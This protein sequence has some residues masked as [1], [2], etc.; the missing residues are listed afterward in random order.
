M[1]ILAY[2]R[3]ISAL[4]GIL[5]L[6]SGAWA[7]PAGWWNEGYACR[8]TVQVLGGGNADDAAIV[9]FSTGGNMRA[10]AE[11]LRVVDGNGAE[12]PYYVVSAGFDDACTVAF[13]ADSGQTQYYLYYGNRFVDRP[14]YTWQPKRGLILEVRTRGAGGFNNWQEMQQLVANSPEVQGRAWH[15]CVFD[16]HNPFG[17][18][19]NYIG[20]YRGYL[21]FPSSG[22]Y[23][24]A[25]TSDDASFLLID[26]K[27]TVQWPGVHGAVADARH[28][29]TV[30][31]DAGLHLFEYYHVETDAGQTAEA[32]WRLPGQTEFQV[33]PPQSFAPF[34]QARVVAY[35]QIEDPKPA[36]FSWWP[37]NSL[38]VNDT[39]IS[40]V[41]F[42][43]DFPASIGTVNQEWD[44]GD[45]LT[46]ARRAPLHVYAVPGK[47][48]VSLTLGDK[49]VTNTIRVCANERVSDTPEAEI[50][51]SFTKVINT[52][53]LS[54]IREDALPVLAD[55]GAV[56]ELPGIEQKALDTLR[57][58]AAGFRDAALGR[59]LI[60]HAETLRKLGRYEETL[61]LLKEL[62]MRHQ[63]NDVALTALG[64]VA[65]LSMVFGLDDKALE[66]YE[67]FERK[68]QGDA[69]RHPNALAGIGDVYRH[70]GEGA[71]ALDY[72]TKAQ[73]ERNIAPAA[74]ATMRGAFAQSMMAQIRDARA[75]VAIEEAAKWEQAL[76]IDRFGGY[77]S[78]LKACAYL[79]LGD[80]G[81]ARAE[82]ED[83]VAAN[84]E[85]NFAPQAQ[86]IL[87]DC[88]VLAGRVEDGQAQY[89][90]V[91]E[92]YPESPIAPVALS[93]AENPPLTFEYLQLPIL[94]F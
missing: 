88:F 84:P 47:Y 48:R 21:F 29:A 51:E 75:D 67:Q 50:V 73:A 28:N 90:K 78:V 87:G 19:D 43:A 52:Y 81:S 76:P 93:R 42:S 32:A 63:D 31:I 77:L 25:T 11:D 3:A 27:M 70:R 9:A 57:G 7:A 10:N 86:L 46:A 33:I 91:A 8:K 14:V 23:G 38:T 6:T 85:S 4:L 94:D 40:A 30:P 18:S 41:R 71:K 82:A 62:A 69:A 17:L 89:R 15:S 20:I 22:E 39:V 83:L 54:A 45:G 49:T 1:Q 56:A 13:P 34:A 35:D 59:R 12:V 2:R 37:E 55:F 26:S 66:Y 72:Y 53:D 44:F 92:K 58:K 16:A 80:L 5:L 61:D 74:M 36:D 64:E 60:E 68:T 79:A 24:I 65:R